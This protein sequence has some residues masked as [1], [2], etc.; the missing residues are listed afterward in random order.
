MSMTTPTTCHIGPMIAD[1]ARLGLGYAERMLKG[2]T[3]DQFARL[4]AVQGQAIQ[5][6]HPALVYGHLSLYP[7]RI[8]DALGGDASS[9]TP[10]ESYLQKFD[11]NAQCVDDPDGAIYPPMDE[12]T[13]RFFTSHRMAIEVLEQADDSLFTVANPNE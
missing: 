1:S 10:S 7:C 9:I 11:H 4:G 6:N 3:A 12:I 2:I 13:E 8:V 5:S